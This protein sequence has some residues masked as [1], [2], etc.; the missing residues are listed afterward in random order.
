MG[1]SGVVPQVAASSG[2]RAGPPAQRLCVPSSGSECESSIGVPSGFGRDGYFRRSFAQ[3]GVSSRVG[4]FLCASWREGTKVQYRRYLDWW[5]NF[6]L[7]E[8]ADPFRPSVQVL[9]DFLYDCFHGKAPGDS[10]VAYRTLN[11]I[12][13]AISSVAVIGGLQAG[14]HPIV[15]RFMRAAFLAKPVF[16]RYSSTWDPDIV[17]TYLSSVGDNDSLPLLML[18]RKLTFLLL[19]L[20]GQR[21]QSVEYFDI[22]N[23]SLLNDRVSFSIGDVLKTSSPY[24]HVQEV[25]FLE[26]GPNVHICV[27]KTLQAYLRKTCILR[28][29]TTRLL[30]ATR[31]PFRAA[32]RGTLMRWTK[33]LLRMAG[34]DVNMFKPYSVKAAGVSAAAGSMSIKSLLGAVGW[35]REST[36]RTFYCMPVSTQ[37]AFGSAVLSGR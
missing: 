14:Q 19:L 5:F 10:G 21:F 16:P 31:P 1:H 35:R 3:A 7:R 11:V 22:R 9:T 32:S 12:R 6:C 8:S 30:I 29:P 37:G 2:G 25:S 33:D 17:F 36:F 26:Y 20:S 34:I 27:I 24:S 4:A 28:G 13:S 15:R 23:M 18:S